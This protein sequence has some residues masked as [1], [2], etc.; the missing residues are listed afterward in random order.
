M[1]AKKMTASNTKCWLINTGCESHPTSVQGFASCAPVETRKLTCPVTLR[2]TGV[3]G[4][5]GTGKRCPLKYT[6][7]IVDAIHD[8]SLAQAKFRKTP[9]FGL[10][11]PEQVN[12]VPSELLDP[13]AAW[14]DKGSY[15]QTVAKLAVRSL[16]RSDYNLFRITLLTRERSTPFFALHR[17]C[18]ARRSSV[19]PTSAHPR[20]SPPARKSKDRALEP[21]EARSPCTLG[22]L[23]L[24]LSLPLGPSDFFWRAK[25]CPSSSISDPLAAYS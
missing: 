2:E 19:T 6:R 13:E 4:A 9:V 24:S 14:T 10:S 11:I 21:F 12:N 7:A 16:S 25:T 1:L 17:A 18:S 3:G 15:N 23:F 22:S 8:G 20:L 5:Y